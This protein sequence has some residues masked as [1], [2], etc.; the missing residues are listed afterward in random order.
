MDDFINL[1]KR[2]QLSTDELLIIKEIRI[3]CC[4]ASICGCILIMIL[5]F[6]MYIK[7]RCKKEKRYKINDNDT[8]LDHED[9]LLRSLHRKRTLKMKKN[10]TKKE[11]KMGLGNDLSFFLILSNLGYSISCVISPTLLDKTNSSCIILAFF[12]NFFDMSSVCWTAV[13]SRITLLGT[14]I[15]DIKDLRK[16]IVLYVLYANIFPLVVSLM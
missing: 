10:K 13:I 11:L 2:S 15:I 9:S 12:L 6:I 16:R 1:Y 8:T 3:I 14:T 5:Y 7:V 4:S